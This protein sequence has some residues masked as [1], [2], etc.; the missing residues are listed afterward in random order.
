MKVLKDLRKKIDISQLEMAKR[1]RI[2]YSHYTKLEN[3][4]VNPSFKLLKRIK[5]EFSELDMNEFFI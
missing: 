5:E 4:F 1:L 2:T 3:N